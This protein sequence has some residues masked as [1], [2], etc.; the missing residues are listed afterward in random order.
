LFREQLEKAVRLAKR[1]DQLAVLCLDLDHF[2][3]INDTLGHPI[4]DALLSE[5]ARRLGECVTEHDTVARLGGDEFAIVQ[6]GVTSE[7]EVTDLVA[8]IYE[9]IRSPYQCLGHQVTT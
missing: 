6:T 5:V 1:S 2:K 4:G 3:E 8:R 9:V 7:F